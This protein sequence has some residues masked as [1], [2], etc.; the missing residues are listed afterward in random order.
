MKKKQSS[1]KKEFM[2]RNIYISTNLFKELLQNI[3][4]FP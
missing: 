4:E 1:N 2:N 3:E